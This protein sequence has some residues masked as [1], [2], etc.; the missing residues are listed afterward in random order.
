MRNTETQE[1]ANYSDSEESEDSFLEEETVP[2]KEQAMRKIEFAL[3]DINEQLKKNLKQLVL[4]TSNNKSDFFLRY[5]TRMKKKLDRDLHC[6]H[7]VYDLLEN[8]KKSTKRELFYEHKSI[9]E[10]QRNLDSSIKSI[11]ELLDENRSNLNILSCG[12]GILRGAITFLVK[13]VGVI[14][15]RVQ[16]VLITD[17]L[18]HSELISEANFI[19]VVEKDTTFQKLIDE[20][21]QQM[22]PRGILV[23]SKGYP[24]IATRNVI[25]ML[26]DKKKFPIYGLFDADPHGIEIYL[27]YK[28]GAIKESAEGRG[29][30]VPSIQWIG[31]FPTD[32]NRFI[33]DQ[34]QCLKLKRTDIVKVENLVP[35]SIQLGESIVTRELDWMV[36]HSF[37]ME[38][39]AI[40]MCGPEYMSRYLIAP[41]VT[42]SNL[43]A[44][45]HLS[46]TSGFEQ[47]FQFSETP[48]YMENT[49][50]DGCDDTDDEDD[51]DDESLDDTDID[52][53][54]LRMMEELIDN[55]SD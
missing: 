55:D 22:F 24:D 1:S 2:V 39:E 23:T 11:C 18:L 26:S 8:D 48:A 34:T 51:E 25:K 49:N 44:E 27:T 30:F 10:V 50:V 5:S 4:R 38:L 33:I 21:F 6:L 19:L 42:P 28:Y 53:D 14:D 29:A 40:N 46:F 31:L 16:E 20:N 13:D 32:Y 45:K 9:Y 7:Q 15:A 37:K 43:Q 41:R 12:R 47:E 35:R 52:S 17:A 54:T 3:A 36:Q